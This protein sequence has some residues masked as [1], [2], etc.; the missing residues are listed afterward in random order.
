MLDYGTADGMR[1]LSGPRVVQFIILDDGQPITC[2]VSQKCLEDNC[3][4]P[5][6]AASL[7]G[8]AKDNFKHITDRVSRLIRLG[9][10][11]PDGMILLRSSDW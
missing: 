8:T 4:C 1:W 9:R 10:F 7:L 11:E 6:V 5:P 3:S 2:R